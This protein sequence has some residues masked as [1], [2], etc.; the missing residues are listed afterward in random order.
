MT[1]SVFL[2]VHS[3]REFG[4]LVTAWQTEALAVAAAQ[5]VVENY[6]GGGQYQ[7]DAPGDTDYTDYL[8]HVTSLHDEDWR[9]YVREEPV[10]DT[11]PHEEVDA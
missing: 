3:A 7:Q 5:R 10:R 6:M 9:C 4:A 11:L 1:A 8:W 2:V